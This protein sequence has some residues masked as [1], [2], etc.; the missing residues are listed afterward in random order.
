MNYFKLNVYAENAPTEEELKNGRIMAIG[1][2]LI[3]CDDNGQVREIGNI[4][5]A[6]QRDDL[7]ESKIIIREK[8]VYKESDQDTKGENET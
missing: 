2:V 3:F 4:Y 6:E 5:E 7:T 1:K 8:Y